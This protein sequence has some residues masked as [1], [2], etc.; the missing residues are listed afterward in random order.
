M[1]YRSRIH[2]LDSLRGICI[3]VMIAYHGLWTLQNL[4]GVPLPWYNGAGAYWVQQIFASMFI[5]LAGYCWSLGRNPM[6]RGLQVFGV[7]CL[8][9]VVTLLAMP[10]S[11]VI[12]GV[13]TLL[14]SA[15]MVMCLLEPLLKRINPWLGLVLSALLFVLMRDL[16]AGQLSLGDFWVMELPR[17]LYANYVT[18]F[19]G[20][21]FSGF[22]STDYYPFLPWFPMFLCGYFLSRVG[23]NLP[24]GRPYGWSAPLRFLGRHSLL[25]YVVHQPVI[26]A[27][28]WLVFK[29]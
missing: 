23:L 12:W 25:I 8:V 21:R 18:T 19:F 16:T 9:S 20:F 29:I 14:G 3:A 24:T 13:L 17:S 11:A 4:F 6:R 28:L 10:G 26:Y 5:A 22:Y 1:N 27:V 2:C 7:G 15:M